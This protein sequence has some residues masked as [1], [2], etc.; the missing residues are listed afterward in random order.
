M[1]N[2]KR[3]ITEKLKL[4]DIK[5]NKNRKGTSLRKLLTYTDEIP[6]YFED[7]EIV[8]N[9]DIIEYIKESCPCKYVNPEEEIFDQSEMTINLKDN[10]IELVLGNTFS[11]QG[12]PFVEFKMRALCDL[13]FILNER[14]FLIPGELRMIQHDRFIDK[15]KY[16]DAK[17]LLDE[18]MQIVLIII[19]QLN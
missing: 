9:D 5:F 11:N 4:S 18:V 19:N 7:L 6:I 16:T 1:K 3:Y 10:E 8:C 15:M 13:K 14:N 2:L 17:K 12:P